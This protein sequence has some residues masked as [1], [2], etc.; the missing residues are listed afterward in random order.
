MILAQTNI[1]NIFPGLYKI[2]Q[3]LK[4][5]LLFVV[6]T[7]TIMYNRLYFDISNSAKKT[8]FDNRH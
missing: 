7:S 3:Y 1:F 8:M 6:D 2:L 4:F 5:Y